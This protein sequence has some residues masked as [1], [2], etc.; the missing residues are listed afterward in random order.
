M[1]LFLCTESCWATLF[2]WEFSDPS[3]LIHQ[4]YGSL[5]HVESFI[6]NID[7]SYIHRLSA[8]ILDV[9]NASQN[10][11]IP[12]HER[13]CVSPPPYYLKWFEKYY[14]NVP[15]SQYKIH[16]VSNLW[17]N[18]KVQYQQDVIGIVSLMQWLQL[19]NTRKSPLII[20]YILR[21][22]Q[23]VLSLILQVFMMMFV[24][25]IITSQPLMNLEK[26]FSNHL[27]VKSNKYL[28]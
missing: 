17:M 1:W 5:Y 28:S 16:F 9:S 20:S 23:M 7:L 27:R 4:F 22:F 26:S 19:W 25:R 10:T 8:S 24:I 12:T 3:H 6:I 11:N 13:I 2:R 21:Y 18:F 14:P 15:L